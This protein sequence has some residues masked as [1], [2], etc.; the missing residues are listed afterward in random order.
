MLIY[1]LRHGIAEIAAAGMADADRALTPEGRKKLR[2]VLRATRGAKAA[3]AVILTS[4]YRRA[5]E[6]A[7]LAAEELGFEGE[8][9]H[10]RALIPGSSPED[11]W[12]EIR[13]H[14]QAAELLL[15]GHE[16]LLSQVMAHLLG[17]PSLQVDLKKGAMACIETDRFGVQPRGVLRWLITSRLAS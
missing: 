10:S 4:P 12:D 1:V 2:G 13:I 6:T 16:P 8:S 9:I 3:P 14:K 17:Y 5:V 15:V 7:A 11:V